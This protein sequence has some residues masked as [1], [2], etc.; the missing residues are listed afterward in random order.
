MKSL[1][2]GFLTG[3]RG[4]ARAQAP[5]QVTSPRFSRHLNTLR[6]ISPLWGLIPCLRVQVPL[7]HFFEFFQF[8]AEADR[9]GHDRGCRRC[10]PPAGQGRHR[11]DGGRAVLGGANVAAALIVTA[12]QHVCVRVSFGRRV[13]CF[14][15]PSGPVR[16]KPCSRASRTSSFA[17]PASAR[18]S[19]F[20]SV[21]SSSVAV[22]TAPLPPGPQARRDR[23]GNTFR[24][25][26]PLDPRT[27]ARAMGEPIRFPASPGGPMDRSGLVSGQGML[28][29][30]ARS[31]LRTPC[32]VLGSLLMGEAAQPR[33][34]EHLVCCSRFPLCLASA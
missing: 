13:S 30:S 14:S 2:Q 11:G 16:D 34:G 29:I 31:S 9:R 5:R 17:V 19:G 10:R 22:I 25:T 24:S 12:T 20:L 32:S 27:H 26:D 1:I 18:A 23:A 6:E 28:A 3:T 8:T 33:D 4:Q 21:T 15:S 7:G